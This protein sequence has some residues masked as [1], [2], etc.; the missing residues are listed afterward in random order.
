MTNFSYVVA[1]ATEKKQLRLELA[2]IIKCRQ[3][4]I[5]SFFQDCLYFGAQLISSQA[6][7]L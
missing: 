3:K 1:T 2:E 6:I 7:H 4:C 5:C